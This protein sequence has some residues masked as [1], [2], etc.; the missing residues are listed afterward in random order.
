MKN[1]S[2]SYYRFHPW[3]L[4]LIV[5]LLNSC[6]KNNIP[7]ELIGQWK[8]GK[9]EVTVR[10]RLERG[11]YEFTSDTVAITII[12]D[13]NYTV[14]G[15]IGSAEFKSRIGGDSANLDQ[16][17]YAYSIRPFEIGKLFA[18]DPKADKS[19]YFH[20]GPLKGTTIEAKLNNLGFTMAEMIFTKE[21]N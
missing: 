20:L 8:T 13:S 19:A 21:E 18:N 1:Y 2:N 11:K 10:T 16:K 9:V 7:P 6:E 17:G 3:I 15:F 4:I 12:I 5:F 14:S